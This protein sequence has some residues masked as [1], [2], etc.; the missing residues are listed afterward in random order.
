MLDKAVA[1]PTKRSAQG[2]GMISHALTVLVPAKLDIAQQM[3]LACLDT[4]ELNPPLCWKLDLMGMQDL[5]SRAAAR[6]GG[7]AFDKFANGRQKIAYQKH[8]TLPGCWPSRR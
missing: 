5:D 3:S 1:K 2:I 6:Q 7:R 4:G 8:E